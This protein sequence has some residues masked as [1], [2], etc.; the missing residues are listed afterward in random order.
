MIQ[1]GHFERGEVVGIDAHQMQAERHG[2]SILNP[3]RHGLNASPSQRHAKYLL[4][5]GSIQ[6][7]HGHLNR[8]VCLRLAPRQKRTMHRL[9]SIRRRQ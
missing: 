4:T 8:G 6:Y 1:P 5:F 7:G 2:A 3:Q 9:G